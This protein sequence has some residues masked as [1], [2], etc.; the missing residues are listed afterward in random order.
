MSDIPYPA[1]AKP[2]AAKRSFV[3]DKLNLMNETTR[4]SGGITAEMDIFKILNEW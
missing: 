3:S 1:N 2:D 4:G